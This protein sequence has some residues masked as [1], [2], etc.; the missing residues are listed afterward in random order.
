M[1]LNRFGAA[2]A[3]IAAS[4]CVAVPSE[5]QTGAVLFENVTQDV[6]L[7]TEA[8]WKYGGPSIA[9][10]D[11]N[12]VYDFVLSNHH[13]EPMQLFWGQTDGSVIEYEKP[14][15]T[16]DVHGGAPADY[17]LD[18]DVDLIVSVGGG[19]GTTPSPPRLFRNDDGAFVDVT[20][21]VGIANLGARGRSVRWLDMDADGDL[22]LLQVVARQ[23]PGETGPRNILFENLGDGSFTYRP[24]PGFEQVEAERVLITDID[25]DG[26]QD[27]ILFEPLSIWQASGPFQFTDVTKAVLPA[28]FDQHEFAMAVAAPDIDNDGDPDL[29]VARGKTYYQLAD[30]SVD[31][32][33]QT[34]RLDLRDQGNAGRD[35]LSFSAD[36]AVS[37]SDFWHWPR[38][39]DL[40]LPV[41]LGASKTPITTPVDRVEIT[42]EQAAG[43]AET[44]S[45]SGWYLGHAGDGKWRLDWFLDGNLA[46]GL[47]ASVT[48]VSSVQTDWTPNDYNNVPDLLLRNDAGKFIDISGSL[49]QATH[50]SSW[51]VTHGDFNNDGFEDLFVYRFGKLNKRV[52]DLLL[53]NRG[54]NGFDLSPGHGANVLGTTG[55]GDMGAAFDQNLDGKIDILSGDDNPGKWYLYRNATQ[56]DEDGHHLLVR[57]GYSESGLD[58]MHAE[59]TVTTKDGTSQKKHVASAGAVHSQSLLDTL[60]F[61]LGSHSDDI[62]IT[63]RWRDGS[64][65]TQTDI[66]ADQLLRFGTPGS[67]IA[68]TD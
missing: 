68:P 11:G 45:E 67:D 5:T 47:R 7:D 39:I 44:Q 41:F 60:H 34:A 63:V 6:G 43:I 49:P 52:S 24:S 3:L 26:R 23:L 22:D 64:T 13:I 8:T 65:Q 61:G 17:D 53:L 18:G 15:R 54:G 35:G 14:I 32:D 51:G 46:W 4:S 21:E 58:P 31:F 36:G 10:F 9:D 55:H 33:P 48:G 28:G 29:Y 37:L 25:Q 27:L 42:P 16:G 57:V 40:N 38:G 19:N 12:G 59:V 20:D 1:R 50:D 30:N 2:L 66:D 62:S 56:L